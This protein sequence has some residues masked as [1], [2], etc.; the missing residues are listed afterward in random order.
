M[1]ERDMR[2]VFTAAAASAAVFLVG[3]VAQ[4]PAP[5]EIRKQ[6][7]GTAALDHPWKADTAPE[8]AVQ[9]NWLASFNDNT[10]HALVH[11]ALTGNPDLRVAAARMRQARESLV[12]ARAPLYPWAAIG[13]TGGVKES[14]GGGDPSSALQGVVAAASWELD[15]WGRVR[16]GRNAAHED[17]I[18]AQ[19]DYEFA[20][21][22]LA[23]GVAKAWFTAIQL[24]Q[25]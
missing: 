23:A 3:C 10:L 19:A 25:Q 16:Y 24:S 8:G 5:E 7:L 15:L 6:S 14:G 22:S 21:Q 13:G 9:D 17:H 18:S 1:S 11:D 4:P 12:Q 20:R 2:R